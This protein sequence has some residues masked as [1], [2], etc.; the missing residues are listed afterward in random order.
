MTLMRAEVS[1]ALHPIPSSATNTLNGRTGVE[2][3]EVLPSIDGFGVVSKLVDWM[4]NEDGDFGS[5][6][7]VAFLLWLSSDAI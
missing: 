4:K 3:C 7:P 1:S 6:A 5:N 2:L